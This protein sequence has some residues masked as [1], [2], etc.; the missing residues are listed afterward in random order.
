M[1]A[2]NITVIFALLYSGISMPRASCVILEK[3]GIKYVIE[4]IQFCV[5]NKEYEG[6]I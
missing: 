6:R 4:C 5:W 3:R 1:C 2:R